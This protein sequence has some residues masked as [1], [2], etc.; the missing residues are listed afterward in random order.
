MLTSAHIQRGSG[1]LLCSSESWQTSAIISTFHFPVHP[2]GWDSRSY[3]PFVSVRD[4]LATHF[5]CW[6]AEFK[7]SRTENNWSSNIER[8]WLVEEERRRTV[9]VRNFFCKSP[10]QPPSMSF[11]GAQDAS[12]SPLLP[13][14]HPISF[15]TMVQPS[16]SRLRLLLI[17]SWQG[18]DTMP[19]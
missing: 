1:T 8:S 15:P 17:Y 3:A 10:P 2:V 9:P 18:M 14:Y 6:D 12:V 16:Q 13:L 19:A 5:G 4:L 7:P 11:P